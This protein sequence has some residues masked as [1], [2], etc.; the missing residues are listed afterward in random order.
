MILSFAIL[1]SGVPISKTLLLFHH[2]RMCVYTA[3]AY[4]KHQKNYIFPLVVYYWETY[5]NKLIHKLKETKEVV[6]AGDARFD[7]MGHSAKYGAY[8]MFSTTIM[9][10]VHFEI[11]QVRFFNFDR[12]YL[13]I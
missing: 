6:W 1:M 5:R 13:L 4:Y 8:T 7:S 3:R 12:L 2:I 10:I 11:V 9:K